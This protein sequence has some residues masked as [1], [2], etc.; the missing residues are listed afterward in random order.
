MS[1]KVMVIRDSVAL[2]PSPIPN[3]GVPCDAGIDDLI[4]GS[5]VRHYYC[6]W[7]Q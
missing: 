7:K 6:G 4:D 2:I 5:E 1:E 3:E